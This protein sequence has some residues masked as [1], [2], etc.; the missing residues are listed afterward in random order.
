M[1]ALQLYS[2]LFRS[3]PYNFIALYYNSSYLRFFVQPDDGYI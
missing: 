3:R 2:F 1:L